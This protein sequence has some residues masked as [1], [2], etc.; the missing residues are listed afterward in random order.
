MRSS[1]EID[2]TGP[3]QFVT[4]SLY[5]DINGIISPLSRAAFQVYRFKLDGT[6]VES[7]RTINKISVIPKRKGQDLYSGTIYIREGSWNIHSVDLKVEQRMFSVEVR[8]VY[9]QVKPLVWLPVSH[10]FDAVVEAFGGKAII[11][12][13]VSVNDYDV[14]LNPDIDHGFYANMLAADEEESQTI[15]ELAAVASAKADETE[16]L[17]ASPVNKG[18]KSLLNAPI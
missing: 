2:D 9:Q 4:I 8:Q 10:N 7:G 15:A 16:T 12:Y 11:K 14:E 6:F 17:P 1:G 18:W 5:N 3:M 13:L